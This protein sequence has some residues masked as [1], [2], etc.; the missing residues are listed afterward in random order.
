MSEIEHC[1]NPKCQS[2]WQVT[3]TNRL[4]RFCTRKCWHDY[5][6]DVKQRQRE[7]NAAS[8]GKNNIAQEQKT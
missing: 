4:K 2:T 6:E 8:F 5:I 7:E 3:T 1:R